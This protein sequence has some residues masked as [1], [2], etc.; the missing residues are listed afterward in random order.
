M[1]PHNFFADRSGWLLNP[2]KLVKNSKVTFQKTKGI[3]GVSLISVLPSV[4]KKTRGKKN[5]GCNLVGAISTA[6]TMSAVKIEV[7]AF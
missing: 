1:L 2:R 6:F 4:D 5:G 7:K 3:D